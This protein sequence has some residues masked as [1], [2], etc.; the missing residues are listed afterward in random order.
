M[1]VHTLL[2]KMCIVKGP[3]ERLFRLFRLFVYFVDFVGS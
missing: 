3:K 1:F 2:Q